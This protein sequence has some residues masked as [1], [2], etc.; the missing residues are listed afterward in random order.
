[1]KKGK[2]A[3]IGKPWHGLTREA[4]FETANDF[5]L[6]L[7]VVLLVVTR[8]HTPY[9]FQWH[10]HDSLCVCDMTMAV[11]VKLYLERTTLHT[12]GRPRPSWTPGASIKLAPVLVE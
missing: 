10:R 3:R 1:V 9:Y 2:G 5:V 11:K 12:A 7:S 4:G 8:R 6:N